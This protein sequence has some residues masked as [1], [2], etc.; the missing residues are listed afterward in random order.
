MVTWTTANTV[1]A[2]GLVPMVPGV[3]SITADTGAVTA[4]A[5]GM[6]I[7]QD[8]ILQISVFGSM[9]FTTPSEKMDI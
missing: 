2:A 3:K 9:V 5:G 7:L 6:K 4:V 8:G 1:M